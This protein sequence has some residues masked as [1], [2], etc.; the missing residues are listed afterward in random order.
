[1][2]SIRQQESDTRPLPVRERDSRGTVMTSKPIAFVGA[3]KPS[4]WDDTLNGP[5]GK[6]LS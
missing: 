3:A 1:M 5:R 2:R 4:G 6:F